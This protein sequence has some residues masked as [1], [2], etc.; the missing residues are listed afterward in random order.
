MRE[1]LDFFAILLAFMFFSSCKEIGSQYSKPKSSL[2]QKEEKTLKNDLRSFRI[3]SAPSEINNDSLAT[4]SRIDLD[5]RE[6][7]EME[8]LQCEKLHTEHTSPNNSSYTSYSPC[9][10]IDNAQRSLVSL[11]VATPQ[12]PGHHAIR[13]TA[14]L[15]DGRTTTKTLQWLVD[16]TPPFVVSASVVNNVGEAPSESNA[17]LHFEL[18]DNDNGG[19]PSGVDLKATKCIVWA[20]DHPKCSTHG[21]HRVCPDVEPR[22]S[23]W[24]VIE[25][26]QSGLDLNSINFEDNGR[27]DQL[28]P[29]DRYRVLIYPTDFAGN[30]SDD[31]IVGEDLLWHSF[32]TS[33]SPLH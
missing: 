9:P 22:V 24:A 10:S 30:N 13:F 4:D 12:A 3:V 11:N 19:I 5:F 27:M 6:L 16:K 31:F 20:E 18:S 32:D 15:A 29:H 2:T 21:E 28:N 33:F 23:D 1:Y 14:K 7:G 8:S 26:C 25:Q 17:F